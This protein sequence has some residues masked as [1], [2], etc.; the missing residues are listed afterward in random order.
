MPQCVADSRE[1]HMQRCAPPMSSTPDIGDEGLD[2]RAEPPRSRPTRGTSTVLHG[3]THERRLLRMIRTH[4]LVDI[5]SAPR[6]RI[7]VLNCVD[8]T[9][10]GGTTVEDPKKIY[11][12]FK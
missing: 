5:E 6:H 12:Y 10:N 8:A 4:E 1:S 2:F 3:S 11:H 7:H 9:I